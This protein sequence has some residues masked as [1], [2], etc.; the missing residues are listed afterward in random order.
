M[1]DLRLFSFLSL[2]LLLS[3]AGNTVMCMDEDGSNSKQSTHSNF[4]KGA[5]K[6]SNLCNKVNSRDI[7]LLLFAASHL[8]EG[9]EGI[10]EKH[11][12]E[13]NSA[14]KL[15]KIFWNT[16]KDSATINTALY[17]SGNSKKMEN[18]MPIVNN[19]VLLYAAGKIDW[20]KSLSEK[21]HYNKLPDWSRRII[22]A[23]ASHGLWLF[24]KLAFNYIISSPK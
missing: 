19:L 11:L 8:T 24:E 1:N 23:G 18:I 6:A 13:N 21:T 20:V 15:T 4:S 10:I 7:Q 14:R 5:R 17:L 22:R 12:D 3:C 9:I 2:A 16:A